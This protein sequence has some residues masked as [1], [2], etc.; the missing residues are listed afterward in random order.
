MAVRYKILEELGAGGAG[1]V[2][3]AYDTQLDRYVAV[4]RLMTK[5]ESEQQE[6]A[7]SALRK[8][9][10]SLATLQHP[11]I[12]SVFDLGSDDEGFYM[13]MELVDGENLSDW[14]K[15]TPMTLPDFKELASQCLEAVMTA[16]SQSILHRDLKPENIKI[17]RLPGGRIQVKVLDFGLARMSYGAKKMTEDQKGNI[18]GSIYYMAPEQ[19]LR[20]PVDVRTDLYSLGCVFYQA[21]SCHRPFNDDT[22]K[23]VMDA[24]LQH[25]VYPLKVVAPDVP[26]PICDW[27]MW[28]LNAE[29][30][31]RPANAEAAMQSL[32]QIIEAGWF[33]D[34][35]TAAVPVAIPVEER[36]G[37]H[38]TDTVPR[39]PTS[40]HPRVA[41]GAIS[42]RISGSV[43]AR[44]TGSVPARAVP[45]SNRPPVRSG[46]KPGIRPPASPPP[47]EEKMNIPVWVW[48][49]GVVAVLLAAWALWP[50]G[51]STSGASTAANGNVS[52]AQ[53]PLLPGTLPSRPADFI[54][55]DALLYY[56][57]GEKMERWPDAGK[58]SGPA[59]INDLVSKWHDQASTAG[60]S[61]I[62]AMDGKREACPKYIF[63]KPA[64]FKNSI[65]LLRFGT[66]SALKHIIPAN[67][68]RLRAYPFHP[69]T[70]KKGITLLMLVRPNI[71][72]LSGVRLLRLSGPD[73]TSS[74]TIRAFP[75][76]DWKA[77]AT[78]G[79]ETIEAV[80]KGRDVKKFSLVGVSWNPSTKKLL[81]NVRTSD[82]GKTRTE[83]TSPATVPGVLSEF[84]IG[85]TRLGSDPTSAGPTDDRF[86]GDLVELVVWSRAMEW[87]ERTGQEWK[88]MQDYFT[89][90]GNRY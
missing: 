79:T 42:Q 13:V 69:D 45:T 63:E 60:D 52:S 83:V 9:A 82:G 81:L 31:H 4:K 65:G 44:L 16:H 14:V 11:N 55:K 41:S 18:I 40:S 12:I 71:D 64:D 8:E 72:K 38:P 80:V 84:R 33:N 56:R 54:I 90:P 26:Q 25:L 47:P 68:D 5:E 62:E 48:P 67:D 39:V 73:G 50:K 28:L 89:K 30:M 88:I 74:L 21:L 57:A 37:W 7:A 66:V 46:P 49:A 59:A 17:K 19:F 1:A 23:G 36:S 51:S 10:A 15:T 61:V 77:I 3:K 32:K 35:T 70:S 58:P 27:I 29:P 87:E 34:S 75:N 6:S 86:V 43:S 22:V 53:Q 76:N 85:E 24:H 2:F 20:K 78:A